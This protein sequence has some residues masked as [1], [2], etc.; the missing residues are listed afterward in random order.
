MLPE[1][2]R[3][4]PRQGRV[5]IFSLHA[6]CY[7]Y[8]TQ[9]HLA[10]FSFSSTDFSISRAITPFVPAPSSKY[11][12][13]FF[14]NT[15]QLAGLTPQGMQS[16]RPV[17]S[18]AVEPAPPCVDYAAPPHYGWVRRE[19]Q[20]DPSVSPTPQYLFYLN[21]HSFGGRGLAAQAVNV[22]PGWGMNRTLN[23]NAGRY[24]PAAANHTIS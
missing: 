3:L 7:A 4:T 17:P 1:M 8:S 11:A 2:G 5:T 22:A 9:H 13:T 23:V 14:S 19:A 21:P 12:A 16:G 6:S 20:W 24:T 15:S 10:A 18:R